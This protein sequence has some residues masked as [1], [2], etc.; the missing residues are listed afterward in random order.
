MIPQ[1]GP[2]ERG[3]GFFAAWAVHALRNLYSLLRIRKTGYSEA[4]S[5]YCYR[6]RLSGQRPYQTRNAARAKIHLIDFR[7]NPTRVKVPPPFSGA[8]TH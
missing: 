7:L 4:L 2:A 6:F 5:Y 1:P 8:L 3:I